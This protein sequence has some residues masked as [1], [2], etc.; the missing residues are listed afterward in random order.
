MRTSADSK[1][2]AIIDRL[3]E[4]GSDENNIEWL[5]RQTDRRTDE[6]EHHADNY[7]L[8]SGTQVNRTLT[9]NEYLCVVLELEGIV[10]YGVVLRINLRVNYEELKNIKISYNSNVVIKRLLG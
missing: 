2:Q 10:A 9:A 3:T 6:M 1:D 5:D 7:G 8:F 4:V